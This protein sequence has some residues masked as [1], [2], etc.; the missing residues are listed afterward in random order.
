[1]ILGH[2]PMALIVIN[3]SE[4]EIIL[5]HELMVLDDMNDSEL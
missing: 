1:M 4:L 5:C 3:N 2:E